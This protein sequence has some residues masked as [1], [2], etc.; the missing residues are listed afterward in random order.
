MAQ[1]ERDTRRRAV[2]RGERPGR[3][4]RSLVRPASSSAPRI[5][6]GFVAR[7]DAEPLILGCCVLSA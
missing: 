4:G 3:V 5:A 2:D 7:E 1:A 6:L